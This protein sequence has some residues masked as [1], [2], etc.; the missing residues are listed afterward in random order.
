L[1]TQAA[2]SSEG[3][4]AIQLHGST[5]VPDTFIVSQGV[6]LNLRKYPLE[7]EETQVH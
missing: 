3:L 7:K 2:G 5:S 6:D 4:V 1:K